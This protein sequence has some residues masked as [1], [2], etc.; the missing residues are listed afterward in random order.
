MDCVSFS[1]AGIGELPPEDYPHPVTVNIPV[2]KLFR[3]IRICGQWRAIFC[4]AAFLA[5]L[6]LWGTPSF[7]S[8]A[9]I[10]SN[11]NIRSIATFTHM[12]LS[13][14]FANSSKPHPQA[15][16]LLICFYLIFIS[17]NSCCSNC[18]TKFPCQNHQKNIMHS[19][20]HFVFK[21]SY[22]AY[23]TQN[24]RSKS[25]AVGGPK[26]FLGAQ[27][28]PIRI[29]TFPPSFTFALKS[30]IYLANT[31]SKSSSSSNSNS[32]SNSQF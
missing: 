12:H 25:N 16:S 1:H 20:N 18:R 31:N 27:D 30:N 3:Q 14:F 21:S 26:G 6:P 4:W 5:S 15:F 22:D 13:P 17:S 2:S 9:W 10:Q 32:N 7:I 28:F 8:L 11:H 24:H 23:N 19:G 29:P